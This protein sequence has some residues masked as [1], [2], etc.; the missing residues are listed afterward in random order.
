MKLGK[1]P[2]QSNKVTFIMARKNSDVKEIVWKSFADI[3][4]HLEAIMDLEL[5]VKRQMRPRFSHLYVM[6]KPALA[7]PGSWRYRRLTEN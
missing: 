5:V 1:E 6:S 4:S 7:S 3:S 2:I